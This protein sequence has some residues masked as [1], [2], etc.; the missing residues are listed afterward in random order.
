MS[1][2]FNAQDRK[3]FLSLSGEG[4][5]HLR[6]GLNINDYRD[7]CLKIEQACDLKASVQLFESYGVG[8]GKNRSC[9]TIIERW[10]TPE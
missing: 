4:T 7:V 5:T 3:Q 6:A 2:F 8:T 1:M 10:L 9:Q